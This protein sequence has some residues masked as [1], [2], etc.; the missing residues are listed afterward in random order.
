MGFIRNGAH[1]LVILAELS[2]DE[3]LS[4]K[5]T[6]AYAHTSVN[7]GTAKIEQGENKDSER[8]REA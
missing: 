4:S 2:Y 1:S 8:E 3:L 6:Q 5:K 7:W